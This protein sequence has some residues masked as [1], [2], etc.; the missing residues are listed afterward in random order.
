MQTSPCIERK[1]AG[2]DEAV[3]FF[4]SMS[5]RERE[6]AD[7]ES[8]LLEGLQAGSSQSPTNRRSDRR[9]SQVRLEALARWQHH[10]RGNVPPNQFIHVP[11]TP[12]SSTC[13][14]MAVLVRC[15]QDAHL[16]K[17]RDGRQIKIAVNVSASQLRLPDFTNQ[18]LSTIQQSGLAPSDF[19]VE[20][21]ETVFADDDPFRNAIREF[22]KKPV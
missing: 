18:F 20:I 19:D 11:R 10:K 1:D 14:G 3:R 5:R 8:D 12:D 22:P 4:E 7:L 16:F 15:C 2:G 9:R 21:L 17:D 6:R 13:S